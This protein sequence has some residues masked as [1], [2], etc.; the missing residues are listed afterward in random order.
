VENEV[1]EEVVKGE[2]G[3]AE[4]SR[5]VR[6]RRGQSSTKMSQMMMMRKTSLNLDSSQGSADAF[7][8]EDVDIDIDDDDD[9]SDSRSTKTTDR[10]ETTLFIR[11]LP[12]TT[13]DDILEDYFSRFGPLRYAR[14]ISDTETKRSRGT[15]FVSFHNATNAQTCLRQAPRIQPPKKPEDS[16]VMKHS[17]L[18]HGALDPSGRYTLEGRVLQVSL[19]ASKGEA[20]KLQDANTSQRNS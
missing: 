2:E 10:S 14:F 1:W 4:E 16:T 6:T 12:L 18:E 13:D 11:N 19:A 17:I 20:S 7:D 3:V 5:W 15:G 9:N 8:D